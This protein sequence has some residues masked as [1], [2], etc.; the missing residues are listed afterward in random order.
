MAHY[1]ESA[2]WRRFATI[3]QQLHR[4]RG[5]RNLV[6]LQRALYLVVALVAAGAALFIVLALATSARLFAV[7]TWSVVAAVLASAALVVVETRRRWLGR[8]QSAAWIDRRFTLGGRLTSVVEIHG[9]AETG[10][11]FPF[12]LLPRSLT[13]WDARARRAATHPA[14][15]LATPQRSALALTI[16]LPRAPRVP[17]TIDGR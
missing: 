16:A 12:C 1:V 7:L 6:E 11:L 4:V 10:R 3:E 13:V 2:R 8:A 15:A 17:E 9:H 14:P 5:R